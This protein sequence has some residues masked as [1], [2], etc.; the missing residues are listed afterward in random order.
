M[1]TNRILWYHSQ[2]VLH[3]R[4]LLTLTVQSKPPLR[5]HGSSHCRLSV[6]SNTQLFCESWHQ[7]R[8]ES[9]WGGSLVLKSYTKISANACYRVIQACYLLRCS[10]GVLPGRDFP[11][12]HYT[13]SE[14]MGGSPPCLQTSATAY[15]N[16]WH[17]HLVPPSLTCR[18]HLILSELHPMTCVGTNS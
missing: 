7:T 3:N 10:S 12:K 11:L 17:P 18:C 14:Q 9:H 16:A 6:E 1:A 15:R 13:A 4:T 5:S 8:P 2:A